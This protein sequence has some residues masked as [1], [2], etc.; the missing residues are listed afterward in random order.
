MG[1]MNSPKKVE[2]VSHLNEL[3]IFHSK[4][5]IIER[6]TI[7]QWLG[8]LEYLEEK[9]WVKLKIRSPKDDYLY[10]GYKYQ[11]LLIKI[12]GNTLKFE[13]EFNE[14][15]NKP[16]TFSREFIYYSIELPL[17][18]LPLHINENRGPLGSIIKWRLE[19]EI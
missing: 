19:N 4:I 2:P 16:V 7:D 13:E 18:E 11:D 1:G 10:I 14:C 9:K 5:G 15:F 6:Y 8:L 12:K 3:L 17:D